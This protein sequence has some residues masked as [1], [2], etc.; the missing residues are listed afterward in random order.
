MWY[1][2]DAAD[3]P[4]G[5]CS[6]CVAFTNTGFPKS[7]FTDTI[8][9]ALYGITA[10]PHLFTRPLLLDLGTPIANG[11]VPEVRKFL[12][13]SDLGGVHEI[14]HLVTDGG[15]SK[16]SPVARSSTQIS[17]NTNTDVPSLRS[18]NRSTLPRTALQPMANKLRL[19]H[20]DLQRRWEC[21]RLHCY[22]VPR[23]R[24]AKERT[25]KCR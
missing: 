12:N 20:M 2:P 7:R 23:P 18:R 13:S 5:L 4:A 8:A 10:C 1:P 19:G 16:K 24:P 11:G 9:K 14:I 22:R 15:T 6:A 21:I 25:S 17:V 3:P